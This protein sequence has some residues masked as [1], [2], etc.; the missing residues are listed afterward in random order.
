[1]ENFNKKQLD[2]NG[3]VL[4]TGL[5]ISKN[6][7]TLK[8]FMLFFAVLLYSNT[9]F[10]Q[11]TWEDASVNRRDFPSSWW[12][13]GTYYVRDTRPYGDW[14]AR[15]YT[16]IGLFVPKAKL[17]IKGYNDAGSN[18]SQDQRD[19]TL[20][21]EP[22]TWGPGRFARIKFGDE[23]HYI[24]GGY[25]IRMIFNDVN[26]FKFTGGNIIADN[27]LKFSTE[28]SV[29]VNDAKIGVGMFAPGLNITGTNVGT[30]C[31]QISLWGQIIQLQNDGINKWIGK[32]NFAG[33]VV[34]GNS[35]GFVD[36]TT[37]SS[38]TLDVGRG[39][40]TWGTVTFRGSFIHSHF[41][42]GTAEHTYIRGG[43]IDSNVYINDNTDG[44]L[45]ISPLRK[46]GVGIG[47]NAIGTYRL[48]V[49]GKIGAR[50]VEVKA[51]SWAD[52]VFKKNY[53]LKSLEEVESYI[54][55]NNHLPDVPSEAEVV[56]NG[57]A[58]GEMLKLQMQ[59]IEELT[60]YLI[61]QNKRIQAL[62]K[63]NIQ[64]QKQ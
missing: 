53:N 5:R 27:Y 23:N 59:K 24:K 35:T 45:Y 63:E 17:H 4:A 33:T 64:L 60:L 8:C 11:W 34:M 30:T 38:S 7:N 18:P 28:Y 25:D 47:T 39:T 62:E 26:G 52:F 29:D 1:M 48:A 46:G 40:G 3:I 12:S 31:R 55:S 21:I 44:N 16:G 54:D 15:G 10:A 43:K 37:M 50:E 19:P 32:H 56:K 36:G 13:L 57:V 6:N 42:N 9:T 49:E 14:E 58:V 2:N 20:F 61:E 51:G 22:A 41:N